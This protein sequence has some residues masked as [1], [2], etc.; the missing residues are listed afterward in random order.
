MR[1]LAEQL[2]QAGFA[3]LRFDFHGTGD[4]SGNEGDPARLETWVEDIG[5]A[6]EALRAQSGV[7]KVCL[8]GLRLGATLALVA[9]SRRTDVDSL[10]LWN[11][12]LNGKSYVAET[13]KQHKMHAILEPEGFSLKRPGGVVGGEEALGFFL[14]DGTMAE[15]GQIDLLAL[16]SCP[17][18]KVL[19][20][21]GGSA[22]KEQALLT[23][24]RALG[25]TP[26]YQPVVDNKF[27]ITSPH[28]ATVPVG[29]LNEITAWLDGHYPAPA[30]TAAATELG[31]A[32]G[33]V[34]TQ[35]TAGVA[36]HP[37]LF[38]ENNR[39]FGILHEAVSERAPG[40]RALPT[41]L[42]LNAG[43]V[44]RVGPHRFY[45]RMARE[46]A[47]QGFNVFRVDLSG[48]GDS[49]K[50]EGTEENLTYPR[51]GIIDVQTTMD[52]LKS[53]LSVERFIV[54]GLCSGADI[55]FQIGLQ[56][57]RVAAAVM[58]NPRTFCV[59][60]LEMV[61]MY[62]R[63]SYFQGSLLKKQSWLKLLRG[64]VNVAEKMRTLVP[65]VTELAHRKL[66]EA[67]KKIEGLVRSSKSALGSSAGNDVPASLRKMA[68]R[69]IDTL[70]VVSEKDPGVDYVDI[71]F[72]KGMQA[73]ESVAG[74][75]RA[76][77]K[78]T[79]HTF[80]SLYAQQLVFE[81]IT[82]HLTKNHV[83]KML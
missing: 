68:G 33:R 58:M 15:L 10:I 29:V 31:C 67:Y 20:L 80:T 46:W 72:A 2:A 53:R 40:A 39:L 63:A 50:E 38:G 32:P 52:M 1:H 59:H 4:S 12:Y 49:P 70:L 45:V 47:K 51:R 6:V 19:L 35:R 69:G 44:H 79:D 17:T 83:E 73:L 65:N 30:S 24:L 34:A 54:M 82:N 13:I 42:I 7:T 11:P 77:F 25:A 76:N 5:L 22:Q 78:G 8:T 61:E 27:L 28:Q 36:E 71:H 66:E 56:D 55:A 9:A 16:E 43:T 37:I 23:K 57:A 60:D 64:E 41:I 74:F 81:T 14:S 48:I 3:V 75:R 21:G 18:S 62:D 26:D